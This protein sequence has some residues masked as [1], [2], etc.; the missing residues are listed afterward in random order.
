MCNSILKN[1]C[2]Y[3]VKATY[4]YDAK[5]L[6]ELSF[7]KEDIINIDKFNIYIPN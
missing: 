6:D 3:K 1:R 7:V 4:A 5:E 2:L